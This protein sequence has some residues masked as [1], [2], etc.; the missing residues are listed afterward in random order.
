MMGDS[1]Y[2][3]NSINFAVNNVKVENLEHRASNVGFKDD[4]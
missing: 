2:L 3:N 4:A 1:Q